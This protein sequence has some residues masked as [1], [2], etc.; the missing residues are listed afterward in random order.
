MHI[1]DFMMKQFKAKHEIGSHCRRQTRSLHTVFSKHLMRLFS[2]TSEIPVEWMN[3]KVV[4]D[5]TWVVSDSCAKR[6]LYGWAWT[7][8]VVNYQNEIFLPTM[9]RFEGSDLEQ[10]NP[11]LKDGWKRMIALFQ[12]EC[13]FHANDE[14]QMLWKVQFQFYALFLIWFQI[15]RLYEGEQPLQKTG[16]ERLI[17]VSNIIFS[18]TGYLVLCDQDG[19]IIEMPER[20]SFLAQTGIPGG[21]LS[22]LL[23]RLNLQWKSL[24]LLTQAVKLFIFDQS[25]AHASLPPDALHAFDMNKSNGRKQCKQWDTAIPQSNTDPYDCGQPQSMVTPSGKVKGWKQVLEQGFNISKLK[26]KCSPVCLFECQDWCLAQLLSQQEDVANQWS[27]LEAL[28]KAAHHKC[29]FL[30]KF[31]C[32]LNLIEMVSNNLLGW[33]KFC[34]LYYS[35]LGMV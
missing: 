2:L 26:A 19:K 35:V 18:E 17:H 23:S 3:C 27:M 1:H 29:I 8:D 32:E 4:A 30:L 24:K 11:A 7:E 33:T 15:F 5:L 16:Q 31:H 14:A 12:D 20:S 22:S 25:S 9:A 6:S 13:Y 34:S 21:T 28:I 10:V